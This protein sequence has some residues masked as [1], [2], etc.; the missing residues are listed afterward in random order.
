MKTAFV[1][2]NG[3]RFPFYLVDHVIAWAKT[4]NGSI[5]ALFIKAKHREKEGYVFP[6]DL[7]AAEDLTGSEDIEHSDVLVIRSQ[8]KVLEDMAKT[9]NIPFKSELLTDPILEDVLG[10]AKESD[11][12][13]I[14]ADYNETGILSVTSF[15]MKDL[16]KKSPCPVETIHAAT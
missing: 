11:I 16:V 4:N 10:M 3:V 2:F 8:M 7:D 12:L 9:K 15:N 14:D 13:F 5:H 6:S 1:I